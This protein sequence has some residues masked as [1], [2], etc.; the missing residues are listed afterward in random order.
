VISGMWNLICFYAVLVP[1]P[2]APVLLH[3]HS[4]NFLS[5]LFFLW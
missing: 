3:K 5:K 2:R 1:E 4:I